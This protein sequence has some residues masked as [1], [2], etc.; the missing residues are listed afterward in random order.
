VR[1]VSIGAAVSIMIVWGVVTIAE[2]RDGA[3]FQHCAYSDSCQSYEVIEA[4]SLGELKDQV[5][6]GLEKAGWQPRGGVAYDPRTK[7]YLQVM[8]H[9]RKLSPYP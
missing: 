7:H 1:H 6:Q 9:P 8:V 4:S 5:R 3:E 2:Q